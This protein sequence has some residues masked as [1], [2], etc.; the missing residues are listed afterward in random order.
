MDKYNQ[1]NYLKYQILTSISNAKFFCKTLLKLGDLPDFYIIGVQKS[2]TSSL[3]ECLC[4]HPGIIHRLNKEVH[5]FNNPSNRNHGINFYKANFSTKY[6]KRKVERQIGYTPLEG[7]ATPF[8]IHPCVP[9]LVYE[10][11]PNAK[12]ILIVRN[13]IDRALSHYHHNQIRGRENVSFAE[14]VKLEED[15]ITNDFNKLLKNPEHSANAF[16]TYS[17]CKRGYYD[18]QMENWL[19]FFPQENLNIINFDDFVIN[20]ANVCAKIFNFLNLPIYQ[21]TSIQKTNSG[22]YTE[23]IDPNLYDQLFDNFFITMNVSLK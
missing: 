13:P 11:T 16:L 21:I 3:Y 20:Q 12:L 18:E 10:V 14:A 22:K 9:E 5:F 4:K 17:Y 23:K 15:R 19:N 2:G 1:L 7:D 6:N 8:F